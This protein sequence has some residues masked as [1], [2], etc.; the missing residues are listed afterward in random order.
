M[1]P[2][3]AL[4]EL[5]CDAIK[6]Y[7]DEF[8]GQLARY[9]MNRSYATVPEMAAGLKKPPD[10]LRVILGVLIRHCIVFSASVPVIRGSVAID[11]RQTIYAIFP[12]QALIRIIV[13]L[14]LPSL[15]D[16]NPLAEEVVVL[17]S[18]AGAL[19]TQEISMRLTTPGMS[20]IT[21]RV[22]DAIAALVQKQLIQPEASLV[23][24]C[25][26]LLEAEYCRESN[27]EPPSHDVLEPL[28]KQG[29]GGKPLVQPPKEERAKSRGASQPDIPTFVLS[30]ELLLGAYQVEELTRFLSAQYDP[31]ITKLLTVCIK[32]SG[33]QKI[34]GHR[35]FTEN[36]R[37]PAPRELS[38]A[39]IVE[40]INRG[41]IQG[42]VPMTVPQCEEIF[43][44]LRMEEMPLI[45]LTQLG[46]HVFAVNNVISRY[47]HKT[48]M[49]LVSERHGT[50]ARRVLNLLRL[51][52]RMSA[53]AIAQEGMMPASQVG[54]LLLSLHTEGYLQVVHVCANE[55]FTAEKSIYLYGLSP[56]YLS[57]GRDCLINSLS[58][59]KARLDAARQDVRNAVAEDTRAT[60]NDQV[61]IL[62]T[63]YIR[64]LEAIGALL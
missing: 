27:Y 12:E 51:K 64:L 6:E 36:D 33:I 28:T 46:T 15:S 17:L 38:C 1:L 34:L 18:H 40:E 2:S 13:P 52:R 19:S 5:I 47:R 9:L 32:L 29:A 23:T 37:P 61:V 53:A 26:Q 41:L 10:V 7:F 60:A 39:A 56:T 48:I 30:I 43:T 58:H 45:I 20:S 35:C 21:T 62:S 63:V 24:R 16:L 14:F 11:R 22:E 25:E 4:Q 42:E 3:A 50:Y 54:S 59:I 57:V 49:Q 55:L 44:L 8:A 31:Q